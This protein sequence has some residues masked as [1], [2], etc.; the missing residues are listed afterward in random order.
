FVLS[1]SGHIVGVVN[2]PAKGKYQY[3]T[4][5][6]PNGSFDA[7]LEKAEEHP[8]SWWPDWQA[9]LRGL[10]DKEVPARQPGAG[11]LKPIEDAPGSY[12]KVRD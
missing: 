4:G 6:G 9:W 8:G 12:V 2:P 11:K 3:W 1:G 5:D 7:W 10:D